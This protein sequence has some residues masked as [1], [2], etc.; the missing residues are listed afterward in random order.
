M[1]GY[2]EREVDEILREPAFERLL[3]REFRAYYG[4]GEGKGEGIAELKR[5]GVTKEQA[6]SAFKK[7]GEYP[8]EIKRLITGVNDAGADVS[9]V[10][11]SIPHT[12]FVIKVNE[13]TLD[14]LGFPEDVHPRLHE[15]SEWQ[16][17][18]KSVVLLV[19]NRLDKE[20]DKDKV[21]EVI[22]YGELTDGRV[23]SG[24]GK[25]NKAKEV[26]VYKSTAIVFV[27]RLIVAMQKTYTANPDDWSKLLVEFPSIEVEKAS[28]TTSLNT[29]E[30]TSAELAGVIG[31]RIDFREFESKI[32]I[33]SKGM[34]KSSKWTLQLFK[35]A[36]EEFNISGRKKPRL[37]A[38]DMAIVAIARVQKELGIRTK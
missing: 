38:S 25:V 15:E 12:S 35:V 34:V 28:G 29:M 3:D 7:L 31:G 21:E 26:K 33:S 6:T 14:A 18:F 20:P 32:G 24:S 23:N 27:R 36:V 10:L 19:V 37:T 13:Y 4:K 2:N 22:Q 17:L 1:S 11:K 9:L 30:I 16:E 5:Q 8:M